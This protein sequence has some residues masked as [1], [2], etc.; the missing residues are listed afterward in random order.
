MADDQS[1]APVSDNDI[2]DVSLV[3]TPD[4]APA[5][6][7]PS[8]TAEDKPEEGADTQ[9]KPTEDAKT[10]AEGNEAKEEAPAEP[11]QEQ[12]QPEPSTDERKL[13]AQRAY[14]ERQRTR[15]Q[16]EQQLDQ[17]YGPKTE[18]DL[19][20][21]G[22]K[23]EQAQIQALRE[24]IA[25]RDQKAQIAQLNA[26]MT[27]DSAILLQ[28]IPVFNPNHPDYDPE[29]T[30]QVDRAYLRDARLESTTL[31]DG[32]QI[33]LRAD[34]P[35]YD[36]YK[37]KYDIYNRGATKGNKQAQS[38]ALHMLSRTENPGGSSSTTKSDDLAD[39]EERLGDVRIA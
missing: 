8:E 36:Y 26:D 32:R 39:L 10:E 25:Y 35:L 14:Q 31:P 33:V 11:N 15:Q 38:E 29:F 19:I 5:Q 37:E 17:T 7:A 6:D 27:H 34:V 1:N 13:Q 28:E 16:L 20:E 22:M 21:E 23:P 2:A 30:E 9:D 4:I 24:E 3:D 12:A 18:E